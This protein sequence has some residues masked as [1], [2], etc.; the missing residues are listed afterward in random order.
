M[1]RI[2]IQDL[3]Y[4]LRTLGRAPGFTAAAVATLALGIAATTVLF[5]VVNGVLL[6]PLPYPHPDQLAL[7][8]AAYPQRGVDRGTLSIPDFRDWSERSRTVSRM[9]VYST[10]PSDLV[11]Q[12]DTGA[13]ELA[14]THVSWGVFPTLGV[15]PAL[16]RTFRPEEED[17]AARVVVL[18]HNAWTRYFGADPGM[19]D[20]VVTLSDQTFRVAGVMPE[21]FAFPDPDIE[22]YALLSIIPPES[23]PQHLRYVRFLNA[24]GRLAPGVTPTQASQ[25]LSGI[26]A[27][28]A[29]EHPDTNPGLDAA[30]VRPL[31]DAVVGNVETALLVLFGA[32]GFV[33]LIAC[34]NVANLMLARAV[35]RKREVAV[36]AAL[37]ASRG[38]IV[39]LLVSESLVLALLAGAT[40]WLLAAWG[41]DAL[42]AQ[43]GGL[44]PR[45]VEVAPDGRVLAFAFAVSILTASIF[46]VFPALAA[47]G[48]GVSQQIRESGGERGTARLGARG[49][50][51]AAEVAFALVLLVG[52]GLLIRSF[53][54][55]HNVDPGFR[56]DGALAVTMSL[57]ATRYPEQSAFLGF[58]DDLLTRF[59]A[60]RGVT[61]AGSIRYLPMRGTGEQLRVD[62]PGRAD[63]PEAERPVVDMLQVTPDLFRA[64]GVRV[65]S[66]RTVSE[67]DREDSPLSIVVN[68][69]LAR[70]IFPG[71]EAL[72]RRI[73]LATTEA[74]IVG[75]VGDIHQRAL[76]TPPAPT[77]YVPLR[78]VPRRAM[79][80]VLRTAGDPMALAGAVEQSVREA[81]SGQAISNIMALEAV[82]DSRLARPRLFSTLLAS[83]AG[84]AVVLASVGIS[85]V[86]LFSV[87]QRTREIGIR[88][89][90]GAPRRQT[91]TLMLRH[92]MT[93]VLAGMAVGLVAAAALSRF[94][95][96]L[97]FEVKPL[98]LAT[99]GAVV[100]LLGAVGLIAAWLPARRA[101]GI[102]PIVALRQE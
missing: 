8:Y 66:G 41:V 16:G 99:Y 46:G 13:R 71:E 64:L 36:R 9:G 98:D 95:A 96:A 74:T 93:P 6:R 90:L 24:V 11:L 33:L 32:V 75:I 81:D 89:A 2:A 48:T 62:V 82:I 80:F 43:S 23:I 102:D 58:H 56:P 68:Q 12:T 3:R 52:A 77:V 59:R 14:T 67:D 88:M 19:L 85:A 18:S 40:A 69:A 4:G 55:L 83:F 39:A 27:A 15:E 100:V 61:A 10:L 101:A 72:G 42:L 20:R 63:V 25:E 35:K 94:L 87:R 51:V 34:V 21:G 31:R 70:A 22:A 37:G 65:I 54:T 28:L 78:Q 76:E 79:T 49:T 30:A 57:P 86:V 1:L 44:I 50:L 97:L 7:I 73:G 53:W 38:R 92:G 45:A 91:V 17:G 26:A 29:A 47:T 5:T 60:L 84:L